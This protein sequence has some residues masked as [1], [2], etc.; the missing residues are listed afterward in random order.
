[1]MFFK[2]S[3]KTACW[4]K[5]QLEKWGQIMYDVIVVNIKHNEFR[6]FCIYVLFEDVL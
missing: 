1:M 3:K 5:L 6:W 2:Q 4:K